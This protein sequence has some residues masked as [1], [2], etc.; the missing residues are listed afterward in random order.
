MEKSILNF[1]PFF[2]EFYNSLLKN[3]NILRIFRKCKKSDMLLH[4]YH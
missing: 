2:E 1:C 4:C 3:Q